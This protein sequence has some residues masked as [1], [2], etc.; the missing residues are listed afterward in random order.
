[1]AS[2][3][4]ANETAS[5]W[6]QAIF[7]SPISIAANTTYIVSYYAPAGHY[8]ADTNFFATSGVDNPPLHALANG[9]SGGN[10]VYVYATGG[11]FPS[12]TFNSTN[13]W[14]DVVFTPTPTWSI[15][16]TITGGAGAT[17]T[18]SG[19]GNATVTAD[20]S[21]NYSFS[22][23]ANGA[24]TATPSKTGF[25]FNPTNASVTIN[26]ANVTGVNFTAT[27]VPTWAI[28]GTISPI[29][30]GAGATVRL[31]G[32]GSTTVTADSSGNYTYSNVA[33]GSYTVT[34]SK[35]GYTFNPVNASVTVN[36][37][38]IT[39]VNFTAT[40]VPTF[41]IS[42]TITGGSGATVTLSGAG[43]ATVTA[44]SSGNYSFSGLANGG[45]TVT[46]TK[47]GFTFSPTS[48]AVTV[49]GANVSSVNFTAK[50]VI[51]IDAKTSVDQG[52]ASST[53]KSSPFSTSSANELLL[54]FVATDYLSGTNTTVS[55]IAGA[56]LTWALVK[57]T[58]AQSGTAEIW[59]AFATSPLSNVTVTATLSHSVIS[60]MTVVSFAGVDPSGTNGSGA[61]G[62]TG[63]GNARSG[64]PTASLVTTRNNSWVFGVGND[65]DNAIARAPGTA[66]SLVHQYLTS[67]GDTYW[68]QMQNSPT[69]AT[70]TSVNISDTAPT[71]D[72]YNLSICEIL[73]AP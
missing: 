56:G 52:T 6:Q 68:V 60:S 59:R 53:V 51:S 73:Q 55:S 33:N 69:P 20:S 72:Q 39:G 65:F 23:L 16:G 49:S 15:S 9:V 47:T 35:T 13:Y 30:G 71:S 3:T 50:P 48:Q 42:G 57:R 34:P 58:N 28:S 36:G 4:F 2:V 62:A 19:A 67:T 22:N 40:A 63:T 64:A 38:N 26:G 44:D 5:G 66:Q 10:G 11:G 45:Y 12:N 70:G 29:A 21:G 46:P 25:T 1:L 17:V 37:A 24:Y 27:T 18:L 8:A 61:V 43:S 41:S 54:A 7:S 14:V 32:A 31:S